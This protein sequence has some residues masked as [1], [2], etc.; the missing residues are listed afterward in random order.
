MSLGQAQLLADGQP[1]RFAL[2]RTVEILCYLLRFPHR[3]REHLLV[4][5][6]P[7]TDPKKAVNYLHQM[8]HDLEQSVS[9]LSVAY[10]RRAHTYA[11]VHPGIELTWDG[12]GRSE[13]FQ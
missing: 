1:V 4:A 8:R 13:L 11:L 5:L 12:L 10:D 6:W 9:G 7:D 3:R 2:K